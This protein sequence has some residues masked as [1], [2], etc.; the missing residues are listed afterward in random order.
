MNYKESSGIWQKV[1]AREIGVAI[2][3]GLATVQGL[4]GRLRT[5][6]FNKR[7]DSLCGCFVA[8]DLLVGFTD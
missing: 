5:G 2:M 7:E 1:V 4:L 6:I 3:R 8:V